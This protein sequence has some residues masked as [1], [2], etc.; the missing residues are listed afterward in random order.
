LH[1]ARCE[2]AQEEC[3]GYQKQRVPRYMRALFG[4]KEFDEHGREDAQQ[5]EPP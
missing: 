4:L 1:F 2:R 5:A 3:A